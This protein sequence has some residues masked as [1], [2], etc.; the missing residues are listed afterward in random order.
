MTLN[1]YLLNSEKF[2]L[3]REKAM[4]VGSTISKYTEKGDVVLIAKNPGEELI[5]LFWG[6]LLYG[7]VPFV[8]QVLPSQV[9]SLRDLLNIKFAI[10][11]KRDS[12]NI[13]EFIPA[14][15][16][17][18]E[19]EIV[20]RP[21]VTMDDVAFVQVITENDID[22]VTR[23]THKAAVEHCVEYGTKLNVDKTSKIQSF[24]P[25][26]IN[27]GLITMVLMPVVFDCESKLF[28]SFGVNGPSILKTVTEYQ[29][30]HVWLRWHMLRSITTLPKESFDG[31]N[32]SSV[33]HLVDTENFNDLKDYSDFVGKMHDHGLGS[34]VLSCCF[35]SE[36]NIFAVAQS[37]GIKMSEAANVSSGRHIT[38]V[39]ILIMNDNN[40]DISESKQVG[41]IMVRSGTL[42]CD[43]KGPYGYVDTGKQGFMEEGELFVT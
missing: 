33:K 18:E 23:V 25:V 29:P 43:E 42:T 4:K 17:I 5:T 24:L 2:S 7:R 3:I 32:F 19:S 26:Y 11:D 15:L 22:K 13:G 21:V 40:E 34:D 38:G 8:K 27:G 36:K 39:S 16:E 9:K 10:C 35:V 12:G 30:T 31:A 1:D 14:R 37:D 20:D 6:C 28:D 41:R